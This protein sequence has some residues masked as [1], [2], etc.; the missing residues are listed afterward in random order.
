MSLLSKV[1]FPFM[2]VSISLHQTPVHLSSLANKQTMILCNTRCNRKGEKMM[3]SMSKY[4]T[5]R[6]CHTDSEAVSPPGASL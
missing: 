1:S 4:L 3:F 6:V 5:L 2:R